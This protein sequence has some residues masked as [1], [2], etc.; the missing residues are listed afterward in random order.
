M[1]S[2]CNNIDNSQSYLLQFC[3]PQQTEEFKQKV[4][5][6]YFKDIFNDLVARSNDVSKGINKITL[7]NYCHLPGL[8]AERLFIVL[9]VDCN[10]Y[11]SYDEFLNGMFCFYCS[12]FD[13]KLKFV[14]QIYD[15]NGDGFINKN[16]IITLMSCIPINQIT[17]I[18]SE[19]LIT[20]E[21][22]G[23]Q[24]F[25]ERVDTLEELHQLL[26]KCFGIRI[27]LNI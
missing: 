7:I 11:L 16:D 23:S 18:R 21:G 17:N 20:R 22:C 8:L 15:F 9:D 5:V 24:N 12:N 19:G 10:S 6:P 1:K 3:E 14:F 26:K 25:Q 13:E 4:F 27:S 2:V